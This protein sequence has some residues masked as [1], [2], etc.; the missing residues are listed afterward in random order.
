MMPAIFFNKMDEV[1]GVD[2][3]EEVDG[4]STLCLCPFIP[5]SLFT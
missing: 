2:R 4:V 5:L 1:D 3:V